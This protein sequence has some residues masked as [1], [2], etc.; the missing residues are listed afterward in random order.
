M[1]Y[2]VWLQFFFCL[3]T[4]L[5][6]YVNEACEWRLTSIAVLCKVMVLQNVITKLYYFCL[7]IVQFNL[8]QIYFKNKTSSHNKDI[9]KKIYLYAFETC[10][11]ILVFF[12]LGNRMVSFLYICSF[13]YIHRRSKIIYKRNMPRKLFRYVK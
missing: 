5:I 3:Y 4:I 13:L 12:V 7:I 10:F 8:F 6:C 1:W 2:C 11:L 9:Y